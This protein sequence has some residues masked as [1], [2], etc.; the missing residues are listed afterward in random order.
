MYYDAPFWQ[1]TETVAPG[2]PAVIELASNRGF[3]LV[4]TPAATGTAVA[5]FTASSPTEI[6]AGTARWRPFLT[7]AAS[8]AID[9]ASQTPVR[10]LRVTATTANCIVDLVQ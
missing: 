8:T 6:R 9:K 2:T 10:A 5:E 3:Q 1:H 4:L 7:A